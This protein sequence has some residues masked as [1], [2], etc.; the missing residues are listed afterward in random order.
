MSTVISTIGDGTTVLTTDPNP[1][2]TAP[3]SGRQFASPSL[4]APSDT[5]QI[6]VAVLSGVTIILQFWMFDPTMDSWFSIGS[7]VSVAANQMQQ[8]STSVPRGVTLFC[9][10]TG[11]VGVKEVGIGYMGG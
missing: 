7:S 3:P 4:G 1:N 6:Y 10:V 8:V 11:N 5:A 2:T 9:Q